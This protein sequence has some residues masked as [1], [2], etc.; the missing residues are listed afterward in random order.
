M[1]KVTEIDDCVMLI[2]NSI[3]E[4]MLKVSH[5]DIYEWISTT[6]KNVETAKEG[7][8][9]NKRQLF[10]TKNS[11]HLGNIIRDHK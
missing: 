2:I 5:I 8:K 11:M 4:L 1:V 3:V 9:Y 7:K 6:T 10:D